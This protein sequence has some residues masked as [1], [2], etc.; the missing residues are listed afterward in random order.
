MFTSLSLL[1][2]T[3]A[4]TVA[5]GSA[6]PSA[7]IIGKHNVEIKDGR[8][9]P[10]AL[11]AMGRIG[12][13]NVSPDGAKAVYSVSYYSVKE[14]KSHT[15]LYVMDMASGEAKALTTTTASEMAGTFIKGGER[16]AFL[17]S[18]SGDMQLWEMDVEGNSRKQLSNEEGGIIDFLF[19][20]DEKQVI[21][22]KEVGQHTAI[23]KN[24][25]DLP[26]STGEKDCVN[27]VKINLFLY[28]PARPR[29]GL[30]TLPS[31]VYGRYGWC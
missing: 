26:L 16:I 14:N 28:I 7:E 9:T 4:V 18:T 15:I 22:V 3:S 30:P 29:S 12:S 25:E 21:L 1:A 17:S 27:L 31:D 8:L 24:D 13:F 5:C 10:E 19:S 20:P 11:W 6:E 2:A 23:Q